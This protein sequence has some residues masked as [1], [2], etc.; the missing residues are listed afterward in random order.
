MQTYCK[1]TAIA[2]QVVSNFKYLPIA[3]SLMTGIFCCDWQTIKIACT[4]LCPIL[5]SQS[6]KQLDQ[7]FKTHGTIK[8]PLHRLHISLKDQFHVLYKAMT[9]HWDMSAA[10]MNAK[11]TKIPPTYTTSAAKVSRTG[12]RWEPSFPVKRAS[13][14]SW[15]QWLC[16]WCRTLPWYYLWEALSYRIQEC[17]FLSITSSTPW[18]WERDP[19]S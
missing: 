16:Q 9:Q 2:Q 19:D 14:L 10:S 4:R 15:T 6:H 12:S 3:L 8:D 17:Q 1:A 7:Y 13:S 11:L 5:R 18:S